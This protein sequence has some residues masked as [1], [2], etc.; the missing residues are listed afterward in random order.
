M[1]VDM[2]RSTF[3][4]KKHSQGTQQNLVLLSVVALKDAP[5]I[6]HDY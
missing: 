5:F 2:G 6:L 4:R 1:M 3:S